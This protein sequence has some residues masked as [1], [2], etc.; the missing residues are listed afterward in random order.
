MKCKN[1]KFWDETENPRFEGERVPFCN[2]ITAANEP[3]H[4]KALIATDDRDTL[5][6]CGGEFSCGF[7]EAAE[8]YQPSAE[9]LGEALR[10][11]GFKVLTNEEVEKK[12]SNPNSGSTK[13]DYQSPGYEG[14][15]TVDEWIGWANKDTTGDN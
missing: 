15:P 2:K 8:D 11:V 10:K 6:F 14:R 4:A 13:P 7:F 1:C 12:I 9:D 3:G 5:F